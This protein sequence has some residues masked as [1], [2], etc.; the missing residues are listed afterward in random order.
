MTAPPGP[1]RISSPLSDGAPALSASGRPANVSAYPSHAILKP[2]PWSWMVP[3]YFFLGGIA[4]AS[5]TIAGAAGLFGNRHLEWRARLVAFTALMPCPPLLILDLG[6]P[7]RFLNML[8]VFRPTSPMNM[9]TWILSAFGGSLS[10]AVGS[11]LTGLAAPLGRA[12]GALSALLG[13]ALATYTGVL[14]ANT[15]TPAWH[16]SRRFLPG[17]FAASA[18]AGGGAACCVVTAPRHAGPARRV[19]IAGA[20]AEVL[21]SSAMERS[22]GAAGHVFRAGD[23]ATYAKASRTLSLAGAATLAVGGRRRTGAVAGALMLLGGA[24]CQRFAVWKAGERSA[25]LT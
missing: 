2:A 18:A 19:A 21:I 8:R 7:E 25:E 15:S 23:A 20:L 22:L 17:L 11:S 10:L 16:E 1:S 4:G 13:P 24:C 3:L 9:G 5:A 12:G 14:L 6:R